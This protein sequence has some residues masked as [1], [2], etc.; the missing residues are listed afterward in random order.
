M[1]EITKEVVE[2]T[3]EVYSNTIDE[4][5]NIITTVSKETKRVLQ[6][7]VRHPTIAEMQ[8]KYG[9][10]EKQKEQLKEMLSDD[11]AMPWDDLLNCV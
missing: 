5:G 11:N 10:D 1:H 2:K 6:I 4:K 3:I 8:N 7:T 9:F